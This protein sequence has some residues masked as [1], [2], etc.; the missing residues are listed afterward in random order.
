MSAQKTLLDV[1][2]ET[3]ET[4][5]RYKRDD[6]ATV[7]NILDAVHNRVCLM[8]RKMISTPTCTSY[9]IFNPV[10]QSAS[11]GAAVIDEDDMC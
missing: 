6:T 7:N 9:C 8:L 5:E 1:I 11:T 4:I 3:L 10:V 2:V